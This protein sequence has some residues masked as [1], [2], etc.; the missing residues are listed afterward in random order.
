MHVRYSQEII[1]I[2]TGMIK[3]QVRKS[4]DVLIKSIERDGKQIAENGRLVCLRQDQPSLG[5]SIQGSLNEEKFKGVIEKATVEQNGPLRAVVKL[6]GNHVG[7]ANK[8]AWLPF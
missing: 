5:A 2:A 4:G 8:R 6:E 7:G 1:E 3:C